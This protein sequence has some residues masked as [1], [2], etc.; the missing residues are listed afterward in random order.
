MM[1]RNTYKACQ[2]TENSTIFVGVFVSHKFVNFC[3]GP[4]NFPCQL[5]TELDRAI[6]LNCCTIVL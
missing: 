5:I 4:I 1:N 6:Q 3:L 2:N